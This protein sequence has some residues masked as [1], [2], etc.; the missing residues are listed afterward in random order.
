GVWRRSRALGH[1][2]G[3][4]WVT[5]MAD[6]SPAPPRDSRGH[7]EEAWL[8][9]ARWPGQRRQTNDFWRQ[10]R[11]PS[12][13]PPEGGGERAAADLL[14]GSAGEPAQRVRSG[15]AGTLQSALRL[16]PRGLSAPRTTAETGGHSPVFAR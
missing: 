9:R 14:G 4:V 5:A 7:A 15:R 13:L 10:C 2:L 3:L 8:C 1:R 12:S 11:A 6:R 16:R